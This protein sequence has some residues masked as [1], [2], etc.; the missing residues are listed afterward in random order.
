MSGKIE[1]G[2]M[3]PNALQAAER[4]ESRGDDTSPGPD[5][6]S[7]GRAGAR[8]RNRNKTN[9]NAKASNAMI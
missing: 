3:T 4:G 7:R 8:N 5:T 1:N 6:I 9:T 2:S